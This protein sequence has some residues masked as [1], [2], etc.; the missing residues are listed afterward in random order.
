MNFSLKNLA[1]IAFHLVDLYGLG[2]HIWISQLDFG[3]WPEF[4]NKK[5]FTNALQSIKFSTYINYAIV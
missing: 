2:L 1:S 3:P 5:S 4:D